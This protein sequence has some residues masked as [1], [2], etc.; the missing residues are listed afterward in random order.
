MPQISLK[1]SERLYQEVLI[2]MQDLELENVSDTIRA[3]L[4]AALETPAFSSKK[5]TDKLQKKTANYAIMAYCLMEKFLSTSVK[6]GQILSDEAHHK[7]ETL[8]NSL[9]QPHP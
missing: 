9:K 6:N 2:T 4:Q 5:L 1:L 8:I 7:A 3:L